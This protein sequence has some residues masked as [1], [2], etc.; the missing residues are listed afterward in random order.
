MALLGAKR[1]KSDQIGSNDELSIK[2][3]IV[4]IVS[5][6][7]NDEEVLTKLKKYKIKKL[8]QYRFLHEKTIF[9]LLVQ[10]KRISV[11]KEFI[12]DKHFKKL[13]KEVDEVGHTVF[14]YA[15]QKNYYNKDVLDFLLENYIDIISERNNEGKTAIELSDVKFKARVSILKAQREG[16]VSPSISRNFS[17]LNIQDQPKKKSI[18]KL[19]LKSKIG[20]TGQLS[21]QKEKDELNAMDFV[22]AAH[23]SSDENRGSRDSIANTIVKNTS[24]LG[25]N[26]RGSVETSSTSSGGSTPVTPGSNDSTPPTSG[27]R[28]TGWRSSIGRAVRHKLHLPR[29]DQSFKLEGS[30]SSPKSPVHYHLDLMSPKKKQLRDFIENEGDVNAPDEGGKPLIQKAFEL[31]ASEK[32]AKYIKQFKMLCLNQIDFSRFLFQECEGNLSTKVDVIRQAI[33]YLSDKMIKTKEHCESQLEKKL[34]VLTK[35]V[36]SSFSSKDSNETNCYDLIYSIV[37]SLNSNEEYLRGKIIELQEKYPLSEIFDVLS[38]LK[39]D[40]YGNNQKANIL[41]MCA[42]LLNEMEYSTLLEAMTKIFALFG[43]D[44][45]KCEL[46]LKIIEIRSF[47]DNAVALQNNFLKIKEF[48]N[49]MRV[50]PN[51]VEA[52]YALVRSK[53]FDDRTL[54]FQVI[55]LLAKFGPIEVFNSLKKINAVSLNSNQKSLLFY[56]AGLVIYYSEY[57]ALV[58]I[59]ES[60]PTLDLFEDDG[61]KHKLLCDIADIRSEIFDNPLAENMM[62]FNSILA[63]NASID[64][65]ERFNQGVSSGGEER[66]EIVKEIAY[67]LRSLTLQFYQVFSISEFDDKNWSRIGRMILSPNVVLLTENYDH[68]SSFFKSQIVSRD[69]YHALNVMRFLFEVMEMLYQSEDKI[70]PDLHSLTL[71]HTVLNSEAIL[72]LTEELFV[73]DV[74]YKRFMSELDNVFLKLPTQVLEHAREVRAHFSGTLPGLPLFQKVLEK[75]GENTF[76]L[77][78]LE[79]TGKVLHELMSLQF[80][81]L[82]KVS[83]RKTNLPQQLRNMK[84]EDDN[85]IFTKSLQ[86]KPRRIRLETN[87]TSYKDEFNRLDE[88]LQLLKEYPS[89]L[90]VFTDKNKDKYYKLTEIVECLENWW[91]KVKIPSNQRR[92]ARDR[93]FVFL[94][95]IEMCLRNKE[96]NFPLETSKENAVEESSG[97]AHK[98]ESESEVLLKSIVQLKNKL[99]P[100]PIDAIREEFKTLNSQFIDSEQQPLKHVVFKGK[101]YSFSDLINALEQWW[102]DLEMAVEDNDIN[103][104]VREFKTFLNTFRDYFKNKNNTVE[105]LKLLS[106]IK[107]LQDKI[108]HAS[109]LVE[110]KKHR[111]RSTSMLTQSGVKPKSSLSSK[112]RGEQSLDNLTTLE[113]NKT[114]PKSRS[115]SLSGCRAESSQPVS[116]YD[117]AISG[118]DVVSKS[119]EGSPRDSLMLPQYEAALSRSRSNSFAATKSRSGS[120]SADVKEDLSLGSLQDEIKAKEIQ[121]SSPNTSPR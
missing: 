99:K 92:A 18:P 17:Q 61:S 113:M 114:V 26:R 116:Y 6:Q 96:I 60:K 72:R 86:I 39:Y 102:T 85:M 41:C 118:S 23:P 3:G 62:H 90:I 95:D 53:E 15:A 9:Q 20:S 16:I 120:F 69:H 94:N 28:G 35:N 47:G 80:S 105:L 31:A 97:S 48:V 36:R 46:L 44:K 65:I 49:G 106:A 38:R 29:V 19:K 74:N 1:K 115:G 8:C 121:N 22:R 21:D 4:N 7:E 2:A 77:D 110:A 112:N 98:S 55:A 81:A 34:E 54:T 30:T 89:T 79:M 13:G 25:D 57:A 12:H 45:N 51:C 33:K 59:L 119:R 103:E 52:L 14:H 68:L 40:E 71:I 84:P 76:I 91:S 63:N 10:H 104:V 73:S 109:P 108:E 66:K 82:F 70:G 43:G 111:R 67:E 11:L 24:S 88:Y 83:V 87:N 64:F 58:K 56:I 93:F 27:G 50:K 5:G 107:Q 78:E 42:L 117:V 100:I 32:D 37:Y 75:T 101:S